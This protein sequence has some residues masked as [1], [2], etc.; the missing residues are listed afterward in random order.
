MECWAFM[1]FSL[2]LRELRPRVIMLRRYGCGAANLTVVHRGVSVMLQRYACPLSHDGS[3]LF[4]H[5]R[6][7]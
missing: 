4:L 3:P 5:C 1:I 6:H 7:K 2:I